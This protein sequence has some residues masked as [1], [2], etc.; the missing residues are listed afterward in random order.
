MY[1]ECSGGELPRPQFTLPG[2]SPADLQ[3]GS[4][5]QLGL[6][7]SGAAVAAWVELIYQPQAD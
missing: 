7:V 6:W 5:H 3:I 1:S 2:S 4:C